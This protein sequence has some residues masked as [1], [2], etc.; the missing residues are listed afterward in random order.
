MRVSL[1]EWMDSTQKQ[2]RRDLTSKYQKSVVS[3]LTDWEL[4][5]SQGIKT[6][7]PA[8]LGIIQT[9][10]NVA[11]KNLAIA[12]SFD[13]VNI[14]AVKAV[15]K[16]CS[17]LV[18]EV[19]ANTKKGI[20]T[21]IK[22]G[23]KEGY[24]MPK[25]ARDLRP[26]VGLTG[27]QTQ[28]IINYR[29]LLQ[30]RTDL[31]AAQVD[32][33]VM[34]KMNKT[35]RM[36]MENIARTETARAQNIGYC[37]GLEQIG[38]EYAELRNGSNPCDECISL[39]KKRYPIAEASGIIPVHPRCTCAMLPVICEIEK[40]IKKDDKCRTITEPL[41][42]PP[43]ELVDRKV[44][45]PVSIKPPEFV[46]KPKPAM[47][48]PKP[49][50]SFRQRQKIWLDSVSKKEKSSIGRYT[51]DGGYKRM[52]DVQRDLTNKKITLETATAG[53]KSLI[54]SVSNIENLISNAPVIDKQIWR[55]MGFQRGNKSWEFFKKV[56][57]SK[58]NFSFKTMQSF[59]SYK[60]IAGRFA[61]G[62]VKVYLT[63]K[64]APSRTAD[65]SQLSKFK[66]EK[67]VL[68]GSNSK[69]RVV[70]TTEKIGKKTSTYTYELAEVFVKMEL[71]TAFDMQNK[72]DELINIQKAG[73]KDTSRFT[74]LVEVTT[75]TKKIERIF[76][77]LV[78]ISQLTK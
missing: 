71:K 36:R 70:S 5:E 6:I 41:K 8:T 27:K 38:V 76:E 26:L 63:F 32:K 10:G 72:D 47:I 22:Y 62:D 61:K 56:M 29:T 24:S 68:L 4:I 21:Y 1:Q 11:Y 57:D 34:R 18:T 35:H 39:N 69:Y 45:K 75:D 12:G 30:E 46:P 49:S 74:D 13:I 2:I 7:K 14:P 17:K 50:L 51:G 59:T 65:I 31:S 40:G 33:L 43:P 28:S 55:G 15:N 58:K 16:F 73:S 54:S 52:R 78:E 37:Q 42:N 9:G 67:E 25:I 66:F 3:T 48:A 60:P 20:N 53:E 23:I 44:P 77:S 19:T 64:Q